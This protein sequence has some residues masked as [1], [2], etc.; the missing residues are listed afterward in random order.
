M[1]SEFRTQDENNTI[2][3]MAT[4]FV[5]E[6][7]EHVFLTGK[8]GTGK[9]T[10]L[11]HI[12]RQT[13]KT[14]VVA[15]PTGV[16]AINAEGVTLH[17]LFQLPFEPYVPGYPV[18]KNAFRFGKAKLDL[19]RHL[20]LLIIDEVSML[21]ADTLDAID[22]TLQRIRRSPEPFGGVQVLYIGDMF[23]LPPVVKDE[24]WELLK[25]HYNSMF[26][27]HAQ[28]IRQMQPVYLELKK[29]YRQSEQTFIDLLNHVRNNCLSDADLKMLNGRFLPGFSPASGEKYITLT[30]HNYKA[31]RINRLELDKLPG[32]EYVFSGKVE[33]EF[34]DYALPTDRQLSLK[35]GAQIMFIKND[36]GGRYFNGK[37]ATVNRLS[38]DCI[39][40]RLSDAETIEV[41]KEEW[42][43]IKYTL[44]KETGEM[45]ENEIGTYVQYPL[46]LAWA[47]TVHKSQ[48]LTF[49][50]AVIDIGDSFAAGQAYVALSRCTSLE[51]I[52][53]RAPVS[54]GCIMTDTHAVAFSKS[55]KPDSELQHILSE[56]RR[57]FWRERLLRYFE[58]KPMYTFL[59]EL[60]RL[61]EDKVSEEFEQVRK[62]SGNFRQVVN[63][64]NGVAEKFRRQLEMLTTH[65]EATGDLT[66]LGERCCKAMTY[67]H[68]NVATRILVPLQ[69][70]IQDFS[71][72]KRARTFRKNILELESDVVLFLEN[73]KRV[74]YN[75]ILLTNMLALTIP[76]REDVFTRSARPEKIVSARRTKTASDSPKVDTR[77]MTLAL[78]NSGLSIPEVAEQRSLTVNTIE[79][80]L[81]EF[82][83]G[84][85]PVERVFTPV[86]LENITAIVL[87]TVPMKNPAYRQLYEQT[88]GRY[89][90]GK[91]KMAFMYLKRMKTDTSDSE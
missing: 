5:N 32:R 63:E 18:Q 69:A 64:M 82:I 21:R 72:I 73:M 29:V 16:A 46:R 78:F 25:P 89:S 65:A 59:R 27:F 2:F 31:D 71:Q 70:C 11:R 56:G 84:E 1:S 28:A 67:F 87:P 42:K 38:S 9:T 30:T 41:Q 76:V 90:Y 62:L 83:G 47:V 51:G 22:Y 80:H 17:S 55:E 26:F 48:G 36:T 74:R 37:I 79:N 13:H 61:Q 57:K 10:F 35:E 12:R 33:G 6:T 68:D 45:T 3:D 24:E 66:A 44:N 19:L 88:G 58:W 15:A 43:N 75:N 4:T 50:R 34:P 77:R 14:S 52:V 20:E 40:V 91:L 85:V 60:D 23:Q 86:E 53:L 54:P 7:R 39:E 8:A 81:A 49:D